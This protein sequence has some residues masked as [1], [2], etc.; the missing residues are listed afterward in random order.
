MPFQSVNGYPLGNVYTTFFSWIYDFGYG[1]I[2]PFTII[3]ALVTQLFYRRVRFHVGSPYGVMYVLIYSYMAYA[4]FFSFF[5]NK[6]YGEIATSNF[7]KYLL[8]WAVWMLYLKR[9]KLYYIDKL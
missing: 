5:G 9:Q 3:M 4:L 8:F 2:L 6:F 1:G 7:I